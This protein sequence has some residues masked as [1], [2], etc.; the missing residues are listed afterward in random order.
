MDESLGLLALARLKGLRN[1]RKKW[2]V[3]NYE[4]V[5]DLFTGKAHPADRADREA[6]KGFQAFRDIEVEASKM[7]KLG[8][9]AIT[10]KDSDYPAFLKGIPDPP[11]VIFKKGGLP[12]SP[13]AFAVVG[14][15]KAS[16]EGMAL[17]ERIA[18]TLSAAGIMIVSGMARGIDA[19]AHRGALRQS[20]GTVGILGCGMDTCYPAENLALFEKMAKEGTLL[21]EYILGTPPLRQHFPERNRIIAGLARGV[22]V[23]EASGRSGS[24]ITARLA[25][26]YGREVMA[27]PG[28]VF[29]EA[30]KGTN[31]LIKQ[32]ARLVEEIGDII[33]CCFPDTHFQE[34]AAV[35][36]DGDEDYIYRLMGIDRIH[37]DEL[38]EKSPFETRKVMALLTRL[39]M[40]ELVEPLPGGYYLRK[41]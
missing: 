33:T 18:E 13:R 2:I 12:L 34:K 30:H 3:D 38:I 19:A 31:H 6:I 17:A 35:D 21:S 10:I 9:R 36:M 5:A 15:R 29:D 28:R 23:V 7:A 16:F 32:G 22:L 25:L 11:L 1:D 41:M 8:I 26:E 24:L 14:A 40:K 37:V 27:I 20:G 39:E 4:S